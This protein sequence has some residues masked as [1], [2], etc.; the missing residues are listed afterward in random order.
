MDDEAFTGA[1]AEIHRSFDP[2][3][4][5]LRVLLLQKLQVVE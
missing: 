5:K 2:R 1:F 3:L 4:E